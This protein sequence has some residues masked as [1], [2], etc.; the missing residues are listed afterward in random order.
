[1]P[2]RWRNCTEVEKDAFSVSGQWNFCNS[3]IV[4]SRVTLLGQ[5]QQLQIG[6]DAMLKVLVD[7]AQTALL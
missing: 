2:N 5:Q 4:K 1:M 7:K 6:D 3:R